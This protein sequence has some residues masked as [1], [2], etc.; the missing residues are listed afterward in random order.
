MREPAPLRAPVDAHGQ[1]AV[2][3]AAPAA[4]GLERRLRLAGR[5]RRELR[6][7]EVVN[8]AGDVGDP[9]G[10]VVVGITWAGGDRDGEAGALG[11]E[12]VRQDV[13]GGGLRRRCRR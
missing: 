7:R 8:D 12:R 2:G 5:T 9:G 1:E 13:Q 10:G 11:V 6:G 4:S 3:E